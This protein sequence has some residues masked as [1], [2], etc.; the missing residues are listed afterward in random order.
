[1]RTRSTPDPRNG[2]VAILDALGAA[3]YGDLEIKQFLN[4]RRHVIESLQQKAAAVL[5][6]ISEGMIFYEN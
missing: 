3:S 6:E 5:A 2:A 1:M 4:S